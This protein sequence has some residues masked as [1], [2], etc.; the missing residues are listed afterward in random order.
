M[1]K[2]R[3][4]NIA[5][6]DG[7]VVTCTSAGLNVNLQTTSLDDDL[8]DAPNLPISLIKIDVDGSQNEVLLGAKQ[9]LSKHRPL[10]M[11]EVNTNVDLI[12]LG[13]IASIGLYSSDNNFKRFCDIASAMPEVRFHDLAFHSNAHHEILEFIRGSIRNNPNLLRHVISKRNSIHQVRDAELLEILERLGYL[14]LAVRNGQNCFLRTT[15][16]CF[17]FS[18]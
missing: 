12:S 16:F 13:E 6:G 14:L 10:L 15:T 11:I 7:S 5:L 2:S 3:N 18:T 4:K 1:K 9:T 8:L 17:N